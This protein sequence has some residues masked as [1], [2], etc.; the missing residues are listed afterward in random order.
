MIITTTHTIEGKKII[1]YKGIVNSHVIIGAN[2]FR[3]IMASVRDV[4][5]GR[6]KSY[7][8]KLEDAKRIA[9]DELEKE[10]IKLAANGV[11]GVDFDFETIGSNGSM[12]MVST[13]GTAVIT[14]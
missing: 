10:A 4:V 7:E 12:L 11:I 8:M 3:D 9:L 5:G 1:E 13:T 14:E 6:S 2:I